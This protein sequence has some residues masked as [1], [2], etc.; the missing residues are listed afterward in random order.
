[1]FFVNPVTGEDMKPLE[2]VI[3][4]ADRLEAREKWE[5]VVWLPGWT[6]PLSVADEVICRA[7]P[8][9]TP[10]AGRQPARAGGP[11]PTRAWR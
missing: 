3:W 6:E 1:V 10:M 2:L 9:C 11:R 4:D 7:A 5:R 8:P